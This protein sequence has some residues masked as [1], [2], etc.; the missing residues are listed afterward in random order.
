MELFHLQEEAPGMVFWHPNG[1]TIYRTLEDY[2]RRRLSARGL[3]RN[4]D[5]AG[6]RPRPLGTLGPLGGLSREHVHRRGG[7]G[8]RQGKADQRAQADELPLPCAGL[9][10]GPEKLPRPAAAAG[11]IRLLPPLRI[12]RAPCTASCGCAASPRTTRISSAPK[13]RSKANAP[14]SSR[15]CP[16]STR[17]SA[18]TAS[19]SSFPPA[20]RFAS[21]TMRP[22]TRSKARWKT[23]S[24]RPA[25]P[26]RSTPA[27]APSTGPSSTSS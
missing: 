7:R 21:A 9:Q 12:L 23:P 11:R 1:W 24:R 6:G 19:R 3:P 22:G 20:P 2:M 26:M 18:S 10:S 17:T 15:S 25:T 16:R 14:I 5:P 4:Q 27:K 8:R 13:T